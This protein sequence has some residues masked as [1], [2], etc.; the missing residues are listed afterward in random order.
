MYITLV[1]KR[2]KIAKITE[3][4]GSEKI[5][6]KSYEQFRGVTKI[7]DGTGWDGTV[8]NTKLRDGTEMDTK[9]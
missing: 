3:I 4:S 1:K 2:N 7:R 6:P 9:T 5:A 8:P